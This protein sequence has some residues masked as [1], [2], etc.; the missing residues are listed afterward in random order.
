MAH[1]FIIKTNRIISH[2]NRAR[3]K[4]FIGNVFTKFN[5]RKAIHQGGLW[6]DFGDHDG[7]W[8]RQGIFIHFDQD[9]YWVANWIKIHIRALPRKLHNAI[10]A[11]IEAGCF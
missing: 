10:G 8:A 11:R 4:D 1:K 9:I 6:G 7:V 2:R 3:S 5:F